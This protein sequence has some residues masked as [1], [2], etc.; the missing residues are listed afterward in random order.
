VGPFTAQVRYKASISQSRKQLGE[1]TSLRDFLRFFFVADQFGCDA[2]LCSLNRCDFAD[3][4]DVA[5]RWSP[6]DR[7]PAGSYAQSN[8]PFL[9]NA[10]RF[11]AK[12][13]S[14]EPFADVT[15]SNRKH[16]V[17]VLGL[18]EHPIAFETQMENPANATL[19]RAATDRDADQNLHRI[20]RPGRQSPFWC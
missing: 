18:P 15:A 9:A 12:R 6:V 10:I 3:H 8:A 4:S 1:C 14:S 13:S 17:S 7:M 16:R 19:D 2:F 5:S 20:A 11:A